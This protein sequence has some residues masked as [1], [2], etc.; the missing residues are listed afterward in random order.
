MS[1]D[2]LNG[3]FY[4]K[5]IKK[6]LGEVATTR[7]FL[8]CNYNVIFILVYK[9]KIKRENQTAKDSDASSEEESSDD[10]SDWSD[11]DSDAE[12]FDDTVCP[13]GCDIELFNGTIDL[14]AKRSAIED[15]L[16][17][18]KKAAEA[19]RKENDALNKKAK[20]LEGQ[21]KSSMEDLEAFQ[22]EKQGKL[23]E[24][25]VVVPLLTIQIDHAG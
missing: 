10:D 13:T 11:E 16:Q 3:H 6:K 19:L 12:P 4:L 17:D 25:W 18:A 5:K 7:T 24:L 23:N 20:M 2:K 22:V 8:Y 9:K 1:I 14:R 15:E 21:L